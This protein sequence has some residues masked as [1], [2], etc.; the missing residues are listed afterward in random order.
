VFET[1]SYYLEIGCPRCGAPTGEVCC[2]QR[3]LRPEDGFPRSHQ[4]RMWLRH[5]PDRG[6]QISRA[7]ALQASADNSSWWPVGSIA[8]EGNG[9][10]AVVAQF[11]CRYARAVVGALDARVTAVTL[12]AFVTGSPA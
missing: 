8:A 10:Y 9:T 3:P 11:P 1:F 6:L 5:N 7:C 2:G 12:N 4:E